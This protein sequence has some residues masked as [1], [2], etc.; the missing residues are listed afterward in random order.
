MKFILCSRVIS[1]QGISKLIVIIELNYIL[2]KFYVFKLTFTIF[3]VVL[4]TFLLFS[5]V[6]LSFS[7]FE[8]VVPWQSL[9]IRFMTQL[10]S[11][12]SSS[13]D[14]TSFSNVEAVCS[15]LLL[16]K[17]L[18][19]IPWISVSLSLLVTSCSVSWI[20]LLNES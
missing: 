9:F 1:K 6:P 11:P 4:L 14:D 20:K 3:F 17:S 19:P 16:E 12:S 5:L 18:I 15:S 7:D 10:L 8:D 13:T 2:C